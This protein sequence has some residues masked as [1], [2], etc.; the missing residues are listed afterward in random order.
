MGWF[1]PVKKPNKFN[2]T[3]RF[4]DPIKEARE[5]RR[6]ELRGESSETD[7]AEY[8]PGI[9]LR[10]QREARSDKRSRSQSNSRTKMILFIALAVF[11]VL[12]GAQLAPR[13]AN[14]LS[15][16]PQAAQTA[17]P[18][19]ETNE[20]RNIVIEVVPNDYVEEQNEVSAQ[21]NMAE[22]TDNA[23]PTDNSNN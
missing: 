16:Q 1:T 19:I 15:N 2:Y 13:I 6:R 21:E 14:M 10:T 20:W 23:E 9:Y 17:L 5:Q 3:P 7:N 18:E 22:D 4:Y 11:I 12:I 8:T